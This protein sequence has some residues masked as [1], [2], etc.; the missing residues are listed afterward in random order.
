MSRYL[1][2]TTL[3]A[4][5]LL[6]GC[7]EG[8]MSQRLRDL[9]PLDKVSL[10][11]LELP[12]IDVGNLAVSDLL[13][14]LALEESAPPAVDGP[15]GG[16]A[17]PVTPLAGPVAL[18]AEG[19]A[20]FDLL[21]RVGG[22]M[23]PFLWR[24]L[25]ATARVGDDLLWDIDIVS[26]QDRNRRLTAV[27]PPLATGL[28][29]TMADGRVRGLSLDFPALVQSG[30]EAPTPGSREYE[31]LR[32]SL[33]YL[34]GP[35]SA[36]PVSADDNLGTPAVLAAVL[37][38][39][40]ARR[41]NDTLFTRLAGRTEVEGRQALLLVYGGGIDLVADEGRV[42]YSVAGHLLRDAATGLPLS[43]DLVIAREGRIEGRTV[44]G[45]LHLKIAA[46]PRTRRG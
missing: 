23:P 27:R 36:S 33:S 18:P 35:V 46:R 6:A 17:G 13:P 42:R 16:Y 21:M 8:G 31:S 5:L 40:T 39:S 38:Q 20:D 24:A 37:A 1:P 41:E 43:A 34:A 12:G 25:G 14:R 9:N 32:Q 26:F 22:D 44:A 28:M 45:R 29:T 11:R 7:G 2:T 19:V 3:A 15:N 4:G 30:G 10:P